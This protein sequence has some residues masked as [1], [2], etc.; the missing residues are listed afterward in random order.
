MHIS[1]VL[2]TDEFQNMQSYI[3]DV[4]CIAHNP[5]L[6][7]FAGAELVEITE[8]IWLPWPPCKA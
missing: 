2:G 8:E 6:L 3:W 1:F 4:N 5:R 7:H